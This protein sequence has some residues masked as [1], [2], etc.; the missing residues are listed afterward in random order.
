MESF[1]GNCMLRPEKIRQTRY[2]IKEDSQSPDG[3]SVYVEGALFMKEFSVSE[4][5]NHF[6]VDTEPPAV[7]QYA[8]KEFRKRLED[9]RS[10]NLENVTDGPPDTGTGS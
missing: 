10:I 4:F 5:Y 7:V 6:Q 1:S 8:I 2:Y 3:Y 9:E